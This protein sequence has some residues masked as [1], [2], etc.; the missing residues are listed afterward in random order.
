[1]KHIAAL[2][3]G[4]GWQQNE[5][6][7]LTQNFYSLTNQQLTNH[8]NAMRGV[9]GFLTVSGVRHK[10]YEL[11]LKRGLQIRWSVI[12]IQ[13]LCSWYALMGDKEI[14]YYLNKTN[15]SFRLI[16][17]VKVYRKFTRKH[18]EKK[19]RLLKL[20]RTNEQLFRIRSNNS[21]INEQTARPKMLETRG[22]TPEFGTR[23]WDGRKYIKIN[24]YFT[25]FARW[26]YNKFIAE[27]TADDIVYHIDGNTLNDEPTNLAII[28]RQQLVLTNSIQRYPRELRDA[29]QT[30]GRLK[31]K[32]NNY[33]KQA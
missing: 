11:G 20:T 9:N 24:G 13:K 3:K 12:D 25:P 1:M 17:G 26:Y 21:I 8:I 4:D 16:K 29:M 18:V 32:I 15:T 23:I 31:S 10:C 30:L 2:Q 22:I 14:A 27:L 28:N 33:E 7:Y 6:E 19:S 5:I